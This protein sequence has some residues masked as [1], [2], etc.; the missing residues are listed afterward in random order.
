MKKNFVVLLF[1][2]ILT[3]SCEGN[4]ERKL[5]RMVGTWLLDKMVYENASG[6]TVEVNDSEIMLIFKDEDE[7]GNKNGGTEGILIVDKHKEPFYFTYSFDFS[8]SA[9]DLSFDPD[10]VENLPVEAVGKV[11]VYDFKL[12]DKNTL[13]L[14]ADF[15][16]VHSSN[17][18]LKNVT[19]TF[20]RNQ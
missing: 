11:Q 20:V 14:S 19:Y 6:K 5:N 12:I 17:E 18:V 1:L 2:V 13:E 15:E 4:H 9:V 16:M 8:G 10:D 7:P 3:I